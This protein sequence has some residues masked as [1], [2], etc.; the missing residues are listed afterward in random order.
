MLDMPSLPAGYR[1][2]FRLRS[3][4]ASVSFDDIEISS[5]LAPIDFLL[6]DVDRSE[7]VDFLDIVPFV[8]LL[9]N[10]LFQDEADM[11]QDGMVDFLDIGPFI[12]ALTQ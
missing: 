8:D 11:N 12:D 6:G 2:A 3:E 7:V 10:G 4:S 1:V 9:S 5:E